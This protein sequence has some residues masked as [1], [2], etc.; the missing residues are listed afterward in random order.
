MQHP[1]PS[2]RRSPA[3]V[4]VPRKCGDV[5]FIHRGDDRGVMPRHINAVSVMIGTTE[6]WASNFAVNG[7][8][9]IV[10]FKPFAIDRASGE[11]RNY[12]LGRWYTLSFDSTAVELEWN[13]DAAE[14]DLTALSYV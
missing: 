8:G 1:L 7:F 9:L 2:Y 6:V 14:P 11:T 3:P 10:A 5:Y 4:S 13:P 12:N